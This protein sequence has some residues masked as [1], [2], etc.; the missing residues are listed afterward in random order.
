MPEARQTATP[1]IG[2][3]FCGPGDCGDE[4]AVFAAELSQYE[5]VFAGDL[6]GVVDV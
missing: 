3:G 5:L 4:Q 6:V 1:G 2:M